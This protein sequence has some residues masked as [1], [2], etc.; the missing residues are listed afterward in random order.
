M[1]DVTNAAELLEHLDPRQRE[2]AQN[3]AGPMAVLAGA[4]TG[5]TRA[6]TYRIAYAV[7]SGQHAPGNILAVTFTHRAA[8]EM[9]SRLRD[10]GVPTVQAR[11]FHSAALRQLRYFWPNAIGGRVP[12][13]KES[14]VNLVASAAA[15]LGMNVDKV[16]VRDMASGGGVVE[17]LAHR[18]K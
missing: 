4:G 1:N 9:R 2:V 18:A 8:S 13:I 7:H 6:I 16:S 3:V 15:R 10:L 11:T 14:K 12:E 5:K 17:G